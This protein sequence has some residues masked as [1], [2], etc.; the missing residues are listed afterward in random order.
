RL[1]LPLIYLRDEDLLAVL[2][3]ELA[4]AEQVADA[5]QGATKKLIQLLLSTNMDQTGRPP[6]PKEV[7]V[8]LDG[9][10]TGRV[11]WAKLEV[12]FLV[13]L[14]DLANETRLRD[15]LTIAAKVWRQT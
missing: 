6:A 3:G 7:Q 1:V 4:L 12:Q 14:R 15:G 5:L 9:F 10:A 13:L 8:L 2:R 11:F